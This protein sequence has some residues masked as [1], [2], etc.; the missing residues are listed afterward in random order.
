MEEGEA[1]LTAT[2]LLLHGVQAEVVP[3]ARGHFAVHI[4]APDGYLVMVVE[5][6]RAA[7]GV[8][9]ALKLEGPAYFS[10]PMSGRQGMALPV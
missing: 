1:F 9:A 10:L 3:D 6:E 7:W 4:K 8:E 2:R 5:T